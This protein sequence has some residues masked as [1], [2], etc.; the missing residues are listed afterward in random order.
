MMRQGYWPG[1]IVHLKIPA[2]Q[3]GQRD[4]G[5]NWGQS[6]FVYFRIGED[7]GSNSQSR[8]SEDSSMFMRL[9]HT[10]CKAMRKP[11]NGFNSRCPGLA[12]SIPSR[13]P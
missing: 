1:P 7:L 6:S 10:F 5:D 11:P 13:A 3:P 9:K 2:L 4:F 12:F 8:K